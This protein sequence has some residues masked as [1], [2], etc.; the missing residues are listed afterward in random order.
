MKY[1]SFTT[2]HAALV[3]LAAGLRNDTRPLGSYVITKETKFE[4]LQVDKFLYGSDYYLCP[5][6][7]RNGIWKAP[8]IYA[9]YE[10]REAFRSKS[11]PATCCQCSSL[12]TGCEVRLHGSLVLWV[13]R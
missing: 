3:S 9:N 8:R 10:L 1:T 13:I 5:R 11:V 6:V 2:L 12:R 4:T 7:S